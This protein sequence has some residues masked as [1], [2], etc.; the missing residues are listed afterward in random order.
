[1]SALVA[2][3]IAFPLV[4]GG[5]L[6][7]VTRPSVRNPI[8]LGASAVIA[9][10]SIATVVTFG[11]GN[12]IFF[13]LPGGIVPGYA[14][15][16][17][18]IAITA[19]IVV[20]GLQH[21]RVLAPAMALAQLTIALFLE[22]TGRMPEVDPQ[23]LFWFDRLSMVMVLIIGLI[24]TLI[25]VN[26]VGYM[27]DYH[28]SN[29]MTRGR[30]NVFF[31]LLFVF[32]AGMF[33]LVLSND[34]PMMLLFWEITTLCSFLLIG[35]TRTDETIGYAFKALNM[36]LLGGLG[37]G[38]AACGSRAAGLRGYYQERANAVQLVADRRY[39]R[40][41]THLGPAALQ[42]DGQG[43]RIPAPAAVP[44]DVRVDGRLPG[45]LRRP[46]DF[47]HGFAG[48]RHRA[49][50]QEGPRLLDDRQPGLDRRLRRHRNARARL[51]RGH[52]HHLP[53]PGEGPDV[54]R[55]RNDREPALHQGH[56]ELR[57]PDQP[58]AAS[59][60]AGAGR[61]RRH[62]H[63]PLRDRGRQVGRDQSLP[64][65]SGRAGRGDDPDHGLR[66]LAHAL[67]LGQAADQGAVD[68]HSQR[69]RTLDR[70]PHLAL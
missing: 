25:C 28:R 37:L 60:R 40:T 46:G 52:D 47:P 51:G 44:G 21:G 2:F 58:P 30:R 15:L 54:P 66:Q 64:A 67:L 35:Y 27:R 43:R 23:R 38:H 8:V 49:E 31:S 4:V 24:G 50:H 41:V 55:G 59:Q 9:L 65:R 70:A 26:A 6:L 39:V 34:L 68:A 12:A 11:N 62:V 1:M 20:V 69:L 10:A 29:P 53:R 14:L 33:G 45:D 19:F 7:V 56:G 13:G 57:H 18:E 5:I 22:L 42:H 16:A 61:H 63:R 32:L 36:N 3:L 17:A 48:G